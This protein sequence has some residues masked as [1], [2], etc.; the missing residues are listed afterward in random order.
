MPRTEFLRGFTTNIVC[1]GLTFGLGAANQALLARGLGTEGR[2]QLGLEGRKVSLELSEAL[3]EE[4]GVLGP[5][6]CHCPVGLPG[7]EGQQP[8]VQPDQA[9]DPRVAVLAVEAV[10]VGTGARLEEAA[11]R[12][13][14]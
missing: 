10:G 3:A 12:E 5:G 1:T 13:A 8:G 11:L 6:A 9:G 4:V 14:P 7:L 2:G